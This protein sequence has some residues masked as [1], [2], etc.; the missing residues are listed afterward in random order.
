MDNCQETNTKRSYYLSKYPKQQLDPEFVRQ[1]G[2]RDQLHYH[3]KG[4]LEVLKSYFTDEKDFKEALV[5]LHWNLDIKNIP[6]EMVSGSLEQ[7][8]DKLDEKWNKIYSQF[9]YEMIINDLMVMEEHRDTRGE[10]GLGVM[11]DIRFKEIYNKWFSNYNPVEIDWV[12]EIKSIEEM[13]LNIH[14]ER[15]KHKIAQYYGIKINEAIHQTIKDKY[16]NFNY[17]KST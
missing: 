16:P 8:I 11:Y 6:S 7:Q 3:L 12:K 14:I 17:K 5:R 9:E 10:E 2:Y 13:M 15:R 4:Q 1:K